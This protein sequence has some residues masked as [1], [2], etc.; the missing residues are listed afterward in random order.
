MVEKSLDLY[1]QNFPKPFRVLI[2]VILCTKY[3]IIDKICNELTC[4]YNGQNYLKCLRYSFLH[5]CGEIRAHE[6]W[7]CS[8]FAFYNMSGHKFATA[9]P[10]SS[11]NSQNIRRC[12]HIVLPFQIIAKICA[13]VIQ[14]D[15]KLVRPT[16]EVLHRRQFV[17]NDT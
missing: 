10:S 2:D 13:E 15:I 5:R 11:D 3:C 4:T 1:Q 8:K 17:R 12:G 14:I 9:S 6:G 7:V 16:L